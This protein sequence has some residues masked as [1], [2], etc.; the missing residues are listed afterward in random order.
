MVPARSY[1]LLCAVHLIMFS[2]TPRCSMGPQ[3][4]ATTYISPAF[5]SLTVLASRTAQHQQSS[6][7]F[8]A[9]DDSGD[10]GPP[11]S[12]PA[13]QKKASTATKPAKKA[14]VEPS[15]LDDRY[16]CVGQ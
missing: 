8:A 6:N 13:A 5:C 3:R 15:K 7:F 1:S 2:S 10:E 11:P 14:V 16:V 12:K 4:L 9:L